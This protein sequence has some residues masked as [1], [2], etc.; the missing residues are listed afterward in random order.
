MSVS[1]SDHDDHC[2]KKK[3]QRYY[4]AVE[5]AT[6]DEGAYNDKRKIY[7][8]WNCKAYHTSREQV[9]TDVGLLQR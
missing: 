1:Y 8:C 9:K 4:V 7:Y 3:F 5:Q 6:F 2:N